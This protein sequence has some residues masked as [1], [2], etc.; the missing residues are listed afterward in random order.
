MKGFCVRV[1]SS[2]LE[3]FLTQRHPLSGSVGH[4]PC[5][6]SKCPEALDLRGTSEP[7]LWD[8]KVSGNPWNRW[9]G[10]S[11]GLLRPLRCSPPVA[12]RVGDGV[13]PRLL[14]PATCVGVRSRR[15][16]TSPHDKQVCGNSR[17]SW[18]TSVRH[19]PREVGSGF[20]GSGPSGRASQTM[21]PSSAAEAMRVPSELNL[22]QETRLACPLRVRV[23]C[24][25][26]AS[27]TL[28]VLSKPAE[29]RW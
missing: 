1:T 21:I 20:G 18:L 24:Q 7:R 5:V 29:A 15:P 4:A 17:S 9:S 10:W 3:L 12:A 28:T 19:L 6:S 2:F 13:P 23:S 27:H 16:S 11:P 8:P 22:T 26:E 25:V 14:G